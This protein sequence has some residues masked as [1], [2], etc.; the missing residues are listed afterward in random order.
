M[1]LTK[2]G[3]IVFWTGLIVLLL[4]TVL[5]LGLIVTII[6]GHIWATP[7]GYCFGSFDNCYPATVR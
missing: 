3:E 4:I 1:T 2:R 5:V 7:E 6:T